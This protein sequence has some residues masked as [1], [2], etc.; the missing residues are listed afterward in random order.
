MT[1]QS[2]I[3]SRPR[4]SV[5]NAAKILGVSPQFIRIGLQRGLLPIGSAVKMS[6]KWT[7]HISEHLLNQYIG[8]EGKTHE[9]Q[10]PE[11]QQMANEL[12]RPHSGV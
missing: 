5:E 12:R 11:A 4:I 8:K 3:N 1:Q 7:Y 10:N 9:A 6:S 2:N